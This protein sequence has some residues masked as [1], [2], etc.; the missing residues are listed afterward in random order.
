MSIRF[1]GKKNILTIKKAFIRR[2]RNEFF[3]VTG[4]EEKKIFV[5]CLQVK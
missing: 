5:L 2:F 4:R 3:N 1:I